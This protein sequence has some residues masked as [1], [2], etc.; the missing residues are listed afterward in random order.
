MWLLW[1]GCSWVFPSLVTPGA[2]VDCAAVTRVDPARPIADVTTLAASPRRSDARRAEV[3]AWVAAELRGAGLSPREAPFSIAGVSG[4]NV[5]A[6]EGRIL[7]GAHYDS[8]GDT[9]GADDNASGLAVMLEVAR[10]LGPVATFVAFD[11]EEPFEAAVGA[12]GRNYAFGSQA[13]VDATPGAWDLAIIVESVGYSCD[14]C[15]RLPA[16]V[17]ASFPRDSRGVYAIVA[18]S[19]DW[20]GDLATFA[21]ASSAHPVAAVT[22]PGTG[23]S[24]PQSRFSD[25]AAFWDAGVPA[26]MVTDT[27]LLRNPNYHEPTDTPETLDAALLADVARGVVAIVGAVTGKCGG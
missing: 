12:D 1:V 10:V 15:Q 2:A 9:P 24:L 20:S 13:F 25:H 7:V 4:T 3:R 5:V 21:K 14:D 26:M 6:G 8:V 18:G 16:G 17:P 23:R 19:R 11:A 27:A 22:I